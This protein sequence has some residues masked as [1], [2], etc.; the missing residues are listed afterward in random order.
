MKII[1]KNRRAFYDYEIF[2]KFEA[3]I[4]LLGS[5]IKS[6]RENRVSLKGS[7]VSFASGEAIWK[8]GQ[9]QQSIIESNGKGH[10]V[11]RE[12]KLLLKKKE[13]KK[14]IKHIE[15]KSYT[16][17]VLSI[18][19]IRGLAKINIALAKGKKNYDKRHS[20]KQKD[21]ERRMKI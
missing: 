4:S 18:A 8:N 15:E 9:I 5:E 6:I 19:L 17:I 20:L 21:I 13:I 3:G 12:R 2:D 11:E 1:S 14:I 16:V 10:E 7:F